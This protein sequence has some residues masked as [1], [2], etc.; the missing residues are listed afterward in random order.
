MLTL[1]FRLAD[2]ANSSLIHTKEKQPYMAT[3]RCV[4]LGLCYVSICLIVAFVSHQR[5]IQGDLAPC[6]LNSDGYF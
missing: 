3:L 1:G 2:L 4:L 5:E 6:S